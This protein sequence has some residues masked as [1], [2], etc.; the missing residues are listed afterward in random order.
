MK[1]RRRIEEGDGWKDVLDDLFA[2]LELS[3]G[4]YSQES[5]YFLQSWNDVL[6]ET[7]PKRAATS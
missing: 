7:R 1:R 3:D 6:Q 2:S 4:R 5:I